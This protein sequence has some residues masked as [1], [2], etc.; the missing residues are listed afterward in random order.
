MT[1]QFI[2]IKEFRSSLS[3]IT[4]RAT[5]DQIRYVVLNKNKPVLEVS[6]LTPKD[7]TLESLA[8]RIARAREDIKA[9][10]VYTTEEVRKRLGL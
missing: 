10:R 4:R 8:A 1:T 2:G 6:P 7:V 5:K 3:K 9:G